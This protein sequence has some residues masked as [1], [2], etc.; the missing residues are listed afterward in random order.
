MLAKAEAEAAVGVEGMAQAKEQGYQQG[1]AETLGYLRRLL[2]T[3][4]QE[5]QEDSY[6]EATSTMWTSVSEPRMKVV[7]QGGGVYPSLGRG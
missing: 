6:F 4:A 5:F 2:V 3:L 1:G 7:T